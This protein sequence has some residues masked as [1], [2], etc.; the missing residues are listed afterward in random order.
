M[1]LKDKPT[2][3]CATVKSQRWPSRRARRSCC[4]EKCV[5]PRQTVAGHC[6]SMSQASGNTPV[7]S[8][9]A[10]WRFPLP[11][12]YADRLRDVSDLLFSYSSV[13][14]ECLCP[15]LLVA[16]LQQ[17]EPSAAQPVP[18]KCSPQPGSNG[19]LME[20]DGDSISIHLTHCYT[21]GKMA[22]RPF[23]ATSLPC[24]RESSPQLH[25]E[26]QDSSAN[27]SQVL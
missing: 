19:Q 6:F 20:T 23:L 3:D 25:E 24:P 18:R 5:C 27:S 4:S 26:A 8:C 10:V 11:S 12:G 17:C 14:C 13:S 16:P 2:P 15:V 21:A 1:A 22:P 9:F 7:P